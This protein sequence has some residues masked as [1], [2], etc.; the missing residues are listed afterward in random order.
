MPDLVR[1]GISLEK[2]LLEHF[3]KHIK[4]Q[5]YLQRSEAI[6]DLI[7]KELVKEEW[8][9]GKKQVAGAISL[10]YDHHKRELVNQLMN[11]QHD[12]HEN[13]VS[14]QHVHLDHDNCLEVIVV[15]GKS[16][17]VESLYKKLKTIRGIKHTTVSRA[18]A[19]KT[20]S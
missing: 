12:Y 13:I 4:K 17:E 8:A 20:I 9:D 6:R 19:G 11:I 16:N 10:A 14:T 1:F 18:T 2:E 15:K 3:D 7:R 5:N